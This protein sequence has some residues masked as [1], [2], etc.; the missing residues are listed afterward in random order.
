MLS[1]CESERVQ[2]VFSS[3]ITEETELAPHTKYLSE[4]E[5]SNENVKTMLYGVIEIE[6]LNDS[7]PRLYLFNNQ[8][9]Y[10]DGI[11]QPKSVED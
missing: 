10:Y 3:S 2:V 9:Y 11:N 8:C 1:S 4:P 6:F 5:K 7:T